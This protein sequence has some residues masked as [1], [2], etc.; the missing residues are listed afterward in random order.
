MAEYRDYGF[1]NESFAHTF[2]YLQ[3]PLSTAELT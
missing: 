1:N 3:Q 2:V